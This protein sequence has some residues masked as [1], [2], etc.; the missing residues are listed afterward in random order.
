MLCM[1]SS[2]ITLVRLM[3]LLFARMYNLR[4]IHHN[5]LFNSFDDDS[6]VEV[7]PCAL[8]HAAHPLG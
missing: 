8:T 5:V 3:T 7:L 2:Q 1:A 6:V 4:F